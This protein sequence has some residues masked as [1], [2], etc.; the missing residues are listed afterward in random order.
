MQLIKKLIKNYR[1]IKSNR[2]IKIIEIRIKKAVKKIRKCRKITMI[3]SL[4]F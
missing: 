4:A 3:F 1:Y 2:K